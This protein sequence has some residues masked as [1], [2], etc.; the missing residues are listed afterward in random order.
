MTLGTLYLI[1][2]YLGD[3]RPESLSPESL[4]TARRLTYFVVEEPKTAR[5]FL[6]SLGGGL[7]LAD[8][9]MYE[10]N[11]HTAS[12]DLEALLEPLKAGHDVG[13][14]S[15]AGCPGVADPGSDL[16][17]LAMKHGIRVVPYA[18]PS[19]ILLGLMASGLNGQRFRFNGYLP[20]ESDKRMAAIRDLEQVVLRSGETQVFIE[21]PYRNQAVYEDLIRTLKPETLLCLACGLQSSM[22]WIRTQRVAD[23]KSSEVIL[24]KTPCVFLIGSRVTSSPSTRDRQQRP[25]QRHR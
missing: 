13:L 25:P 7:P 23:W 16:V 19:S 8:I 14:M 2:V 22:E 10:L 4:T 5:A 24:E 15:E 17:L 12:D 18:G 9:T 3:P 6:K 20:R 21:T 11:E 1:P